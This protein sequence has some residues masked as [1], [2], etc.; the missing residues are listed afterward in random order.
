MRGRDVADKRARWGMCGRYA[1]YESMDD[2]LR[3]LALDRVVINGY[4]HER[5]NR[6]NVAPSTCV[7]V[8]RP[9]PGGN[10]F[11]PA[12]LHLRSG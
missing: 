3:Q 12:C 7:E 9:A 6:Y 11:F 4:D 8:I 2:Y 1:I 5:I 10:R